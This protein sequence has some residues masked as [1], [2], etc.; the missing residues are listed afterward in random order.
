[1]TI[2]SPAEVGARLEEIV[3]DL[4]GEEADPLQRYLHYEMIA[5]EILDSE[6]DNYTEGVLETYLQ[7]Y[8]SQKR[9]DLGVDE[10]DLD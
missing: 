2:C 3:T 1:M 6:F 9:L 4:L 8:L 10:E 5:I 7:G